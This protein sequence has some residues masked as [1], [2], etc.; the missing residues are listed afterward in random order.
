MADVDD[1]AEDGAAVSVVA[2]DDAGA[3]PAA[4]PLDSVAVAADFEAS[5]GAAFFPESRK[6]VTYQPV[7]LRAKP[8]AV[9]C[10][11]RRG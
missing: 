4:P 9:S 11:T 3:A 1:A 5:A 7:P 6:S 2:A 10:F 8:A